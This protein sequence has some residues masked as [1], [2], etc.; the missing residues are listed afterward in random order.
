MP[1][2]SDVSAMTSQR[3]RGF[4]AYWRARAGTGMADRATIDP[5][6]FPELLPNVVVVDFEPETVRVR[7]RLVGTLVVE[8]SRIDFTGRTLEEMAMQASE[9]EI[10][11]DSYRRVAATRAPVYGRV[12]IPDALGGAPAVLEE[13]AI[14]PLT[15]G[16]AAIRQC[17]AIEDYTPA[18]PM[19]HPGR[20]R[21]MRL[22]VVGDEVRA[23]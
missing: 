14:F 20:L 21:P 19:M 9:P 1:I 5:A 7:Y 3:V 2:W 6:D 23:S 4:D 17:I 22:R 16:G 15:V 10:W 13:F 11:R 8:M 12:D 18:T